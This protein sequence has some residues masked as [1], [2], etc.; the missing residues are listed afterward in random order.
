MTSVHCS[1][2]ISEYLK[3]FC[4]PPIFFSYGLGTIYTYLYTILFVYCELLC[5]VSVDKPKYPILSK[6]TSI[7]IRYMFQDHCSSFYTVKFYETSLKNKIQNMPA[8]ICC[9]IDFH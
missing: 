6:Y 7:D 3:K 5:D 1:V 8:I 9:I 4:T 2:N